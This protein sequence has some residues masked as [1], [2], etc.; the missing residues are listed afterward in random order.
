MAKKQNGKTE[1]MVKKAFKAGQTFQYNNKKH[2]V[3]TSGKPIGREYRAKECK[4]D[5]YVQTSCVT[6]IVEFK[7]S[8]KQNNADFIENKPSFTRVK[9]IFGSNVFTTIQSLSQ[10]VIS[11]FHQDHLIDFI[12]TTTKGQPRSPRIKIGWIFNLVNKKHKSK[13]SSITLTHQQ[14]LEVYSGPNQSEGQKNAK[15]NG[16]VIPNSGIADY[17]L[18]V[19][20]N[21][22]KTLQQFVNDLIPITQ[23][24]TSN[25]HMYFAFKAINYMVETDKWDSDRPLSV[26]VNWNIINNKLHRTLMFNEPTTTTAHIIGKDI[27][28]QLLKLNIDKNNF[29][30]LKN[31]LDPNIPIK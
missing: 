6:N 23:Y 27:R 12:A 3:I 20:P 28:Q 19:D 29:R 15:V 13:S 22:Q 24:I 11:Q 25:N 2:T 7:I 26:W 31:L 18:I 16:Q 4:T 5:I 17:M 10:S 21:N 9:T 14:L 30:H 1:E 8:I